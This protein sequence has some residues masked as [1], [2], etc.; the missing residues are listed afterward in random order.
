MATIILIL[1]AKCKIYNVYIGW[2]SIKCYYLT[3]C[4]PRITEY[5]ELIKGR[6]IEVNT[7]S[8]CSISGYFPLPLITTLF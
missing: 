7:R 2:I 6:V 4:F 3:E 5:M 1:H 8:R